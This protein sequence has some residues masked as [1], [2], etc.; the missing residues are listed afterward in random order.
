MQ[1][2]TYYRQQAAKALRLIDAIT[3]PDVVAMLE[4]LARDYEDI[5]VDLENGAIDIVHPERL[6]QADHLD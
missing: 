6:P 2:A 5:A 3:T 4:R 1:S